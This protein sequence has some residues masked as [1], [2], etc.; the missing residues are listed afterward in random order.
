MIH[1]K[2]TFLADLLTAICRLAEPVALASCFPYAYPMVKH[3]HVGDVHNASLYAGIFIS[4]FALAESLTGLF[5]GGFSD[6]VGRKPVLL[7]GCAGTMVSMLIVGLSTNFWV[8]LAGRALGGLLSK[9]Y[10]SLLIALT[11]LTPYPPCSNPSSAHS[12]VQG[13]IRNVLPASYMAN[14]TYRWKHRSY[15]NH[16]RRDDY[17]S[18]T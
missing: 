2:E 9:S 15:P 10:L 16:G 7:C 1:A 8:A 14:W 4:A 6:R 3:F 17:E 18:S 5:W 13:D 12:L 11:V